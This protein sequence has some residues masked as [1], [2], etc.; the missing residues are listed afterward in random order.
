M[1]KNIEGDVC[2]DDVEAS[3][4]TTESLSGA[5]I[6][7][8]GGI[9]L[10]IVSTIATSLAPELDVV[11]PTTPVPPSLEMCRGGAGDSI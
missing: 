4:L 3:V 1:S 11:L 8:F 2:A 7:S 5:P 6:A 9:G 10:V